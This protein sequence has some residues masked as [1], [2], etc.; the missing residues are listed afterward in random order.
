VNFNLHECHAKL[1]WGLPHVDEGVTTMKG[2]LLPWWGGG[3]PP[4]GRCTPQGGCPLLPYKTLPL[5]HDSHT[6]S[7][8]SPAKLLPQIRLGLAKLCQIVSSRFTH[9][10]KWVLEYPADPLFRCP[11]GP[12]AW[13]RR[14]QAIRVTEYGG[15][16]VSGALYTI[17]RSS[18]EPLRQLCQ[19][20]DYVDYMC[21][22]QVSIGNVCAGT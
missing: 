19:V 1:K 10:E 7:F 21:L 15:A 8:P 16:T 14:R 22:C 12:R 3:P 9:L 6:W 13:R 5:L 17:L 4:R 20:N 18:S 11:A 2:G